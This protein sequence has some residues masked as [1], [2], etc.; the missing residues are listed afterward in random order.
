MIRDFR[1]CF[2]VVESLLAARC[3]EALRTWAEGDDYV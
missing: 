3:L 1:L 2:L